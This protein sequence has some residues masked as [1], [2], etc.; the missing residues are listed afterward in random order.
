MAEVKILIEGFTSADQP[1]GE[2]EKTC[3]TIT[4]VRDRDFIIIVDPGVLED[5]QILVDKLEELGLKAADINLVFIT[6]SHIDHYRNIGLFAHAKTL[7]FWGLW[8]GSRAQPRPATITSD[9]EIISTPGH[10][11]DSLTMLVNTNQGK[12]AICGDVFWK[13]GQPVVDP[14]AN[15]AQELAHS[16][17][18][19]LES[20][21]WIIPGHGPMFKVNH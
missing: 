12:I 7:E 20:A 6:H 15:N 18:T 19:I 13:E 17:Q 4:L 14:Y 1:D 21:D 11:T 9:I 3:P 16:R 5:Q 10:S 8:S 2:E